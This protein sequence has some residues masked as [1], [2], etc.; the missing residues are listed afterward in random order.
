MTISE[1]VLPP[2]LTESAFTTFWLDWLAWLA[3]FFFCDAFPHVP[4]SFHATPNSDLLPTARQMMDVAIASTQ[5]KTPS[6]V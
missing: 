6:L 5:W 3:W 1:R 4:M 2:R